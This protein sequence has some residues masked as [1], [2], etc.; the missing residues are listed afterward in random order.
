[1]GEPKGTVVGV[2]RLLAF[3]VLFHREVPGQSNSGGSHERV[4]I[5]EVVVGAVFRNQGV[6]VKQLQ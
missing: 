1:M 6:A 3:H 5:R 2:I 4:K